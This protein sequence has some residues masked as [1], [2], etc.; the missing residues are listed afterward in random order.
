M[1]VIDVVVYAILGYYFDQ[2]APRE[3]GVARPWNFPCKGKNN[4]KKVLKTLKEE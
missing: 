2:V 3:I 4:S 1:L